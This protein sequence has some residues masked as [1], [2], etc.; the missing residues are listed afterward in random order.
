MVSLKGIRLRWFALAIAVI[1]IAAGVY[2]TFI[3]SVVYQ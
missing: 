3:S 1:A 2:L